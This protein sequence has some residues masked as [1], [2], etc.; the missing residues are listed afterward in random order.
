MI[1]WKDIDFPPINLWNVAKYEYRTNHSSRFNLSRS[2]S[3]TVL[4]R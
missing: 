1:E 3:R 4:A 2:E